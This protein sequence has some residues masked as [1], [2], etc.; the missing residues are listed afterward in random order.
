MTTQPKARQRARYT[1]EFKLQVVRYSL[2]LPP[3]ARVKPT[4]RV[5]P[6]LEP[7]QIRKWIKAL[8][9]LALEQENAIVDDEYHSPLASTSLLTRAGEDSDE[10]SVTSEETQPAA[11]TWR[12]PT[13]RRRI[14]QR[15]VDDATPGPS[16]ALLRLYA[17]GRQAPTTCS[18]H[19]A[20]ISEQPAVLQPA[21]NGVPS[22]SCPALAE[23]AMAAQ[24][25]LFLSS[26]LV[27]G[28]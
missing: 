28:Q 6:G 12:P 27:C 3:T 13:Q 19:F 2:S 14:Q 21:A 15:H 20:S 4:C 7:V 24:G 23:T 26:A 17:D 1:Q 11:Q 10:C 5:Y 16:A 22:L 18:P 9:P 8:A 25:L